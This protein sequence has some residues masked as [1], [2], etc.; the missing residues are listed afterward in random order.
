M[1]QRKITKLSR[2]E[3]V[4]IIRYH[5]TNSLLSDRRVAETFS[6]K[7]NKN[8]SRRTIND[9]RRNKSVIIQE[10][11]TFN[12]DGCRVPNL[13]YDFIDSQL[14]CWLNNL[15]DLGAI[16]SDD[17]IRTKA[18]DIA[19]ENK[20]DTF[21]ASNGWLA[22]FKSRHSLKSRK[23]YGEAYKSQLENYDDFMKVLHSKILEY[24]ED[25]VFNADETGL[26]YKLIPCRTICK[27]TKTGYKL[28]KDRISVLLCTN[29][30][31]SIKIKP[32]VIGKFGKPR[33]LKNFDTKN[34]V[35]YTNSSRGWMTT[36]I[37][38]NWL[39]DWD[40]KYKKK[41]KKFYLL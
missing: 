16:I 26:F 17:I 3:K 20:N 5:E 37:F 39:M 18:L 2:N 24:G 33:C 22:K 34:L 6:V 8:I 41:R 12:K 10:F 15:E 14:I 4:E 19:K 7:F 36:A 28:L 9:I 1:P 40:L 25:N 21:K 29:M 23:L 38:S 31:G 27:T 30:S 35:T 11:S 32:I 13:K